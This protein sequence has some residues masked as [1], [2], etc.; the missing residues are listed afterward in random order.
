MIVCGI[1]NCMSTIAFV[2]NTLFYVFQSSP[3]FTFSSPINNHH[4]NH[5]PQQSPQ[6]GNTLHN[7]KDHPH[8]HNPDNCLK[9]F[10]RC[11]QSNTKYR[12]MMAQTGS[13]TGVNSVSLIDR[14][15]RILFPLTFTSLNVMYWV[16][17]T[18]S[19]GPL[20]L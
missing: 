4:H 12:Q 15:S 14:M 19:D 18:R 2:I 8:P 10:F 9:K 6:Y 16:I 3:S 5:T 13:P 1:S 11:L 17:C 7:A 20:L